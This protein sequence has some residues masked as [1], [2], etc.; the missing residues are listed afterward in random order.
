MCRQT[1]QARRTI[2]ITR[3][4]PQYAWAGHLARAFQV[5]LVGYAV[6]GIFVNIAYWN[7]I[8]YEIVIVLVAWRVASSPA[9]PVPSVAVD[10]GGPSVGRPRA[11]AAQQRAR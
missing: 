8:Y 2:A 6:G 5:S 10:T 4:K 1:S 7:L 9:L 3:T 11:G